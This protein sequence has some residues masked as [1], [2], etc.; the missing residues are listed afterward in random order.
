MA[1]ASTR[2]GHVGAQ[3]KLPASRYRGDIC[4]EI[5]NR[6]KGGTKE[7]DT[8]NWKVGVSVH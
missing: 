8:S 2:G 5:K 3:E 4:C 7:L 6:V 1:V